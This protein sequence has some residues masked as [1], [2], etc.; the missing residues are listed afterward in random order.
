MMEPGRREGLLI[1]DD[2]E[3]IRRAIRKALSGDNY[4][5]FMAGNG[6][7]ALVMVREH[8]DNFAVVI[9]DFKMPGLDGIQT[10]V[11]I[12]EI[13][14]EITRILL[15]GYATLEAAIQA[16]NEGIDGFLTKPFENDV[17]R[18]RIREYFIKRR[19]REFVSG[20]VLDELQKNPAAIQPRKTRASILFTDIRGFSARSEKTDP[21]TLSAAISQCYFTP[22]GEIIFRNR[23]TLDKHI[24]DA[25]MALYGA[26]LSYGDDAYRA[27]KTAL[28]IRE[29]LQEANRNAGPDTGNALIPLPVGIGIATGEVTVGL[30]GSN[31]KKEY[32]A[33]GAIVN[34]A[35]RL[36]ALAQAE[37][38]LIC[39]ETYRELREVL[40]V[41]SLAPVPV[42][43]FSEPLPLYNVL[44]IVAEPAAAAAS[45]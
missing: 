23:G 44:R 18:G 36:V 29:K 10:L 39:D 2:E 9:S 3:G 34:K 37:Q 38:I 17:L 31:R 14:Q 19:L 30:F 22:L 6:E 20:D 16:T 25:I 35:A 11:A 21:L 12:G 5:V 32:T 42:K 45:P 7:E 15:T 41:E 8:P 33:Y 13:S 26:P 1:I 40:E 4:D 24:G 27:V 43:G 28:E